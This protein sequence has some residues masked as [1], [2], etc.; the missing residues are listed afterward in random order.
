MLLLECAFQ[1]SSSKKIII[2][3]NDIADIDG[4]AQLTKDEFTDPEMNEVPEDMTPEQ[5]RQ[6][7]LKDFGSADED[8]NGIVDRKELLVCG[9]SYIHLILTC[10]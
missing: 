2:L 9:C 3:I 4:D 8:K 1:L 5:Y 7:R 6:D 10:H